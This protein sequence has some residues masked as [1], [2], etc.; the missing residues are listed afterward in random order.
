MAFTQKRSF[1]NPLEKVPLFPSRRASTPRA[2]PL[3]AP[4]TRSEDPNVM[5]GAAKGII[6][7]ILE[8]RLG[9]A[10]AQSVGQQIGRPGATIEGVLSG[11]SATGSAE[12]GRE[13]A[14]IQSE[15][16][17]QR[18]GVMPG[19]SQKSAVAE[20]A[21]SGAVSGIG[22][23]PIGM[24]VGAAAGAVGGALKN[25]KSNE[26]REDVRRHLENTRGLAT[27][28][29]FGDQVEKAGTAPAEAALAG[30]AGARRA[31]DLEAA[32]TASGLRDTGI[33]TL[34]SIAAGVQVPLEGLAATFGQALGEVHK[35]TSK[36]LGQPVGQ[37]GRDPIAMALEGLATLFLT[38][39]AT[40]ANPKAATKVP[41]NTGFETPPIFPVAKPEANPNPWGTMNPGGAL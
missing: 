28:E 15:I 18:E 22:G 27:P 14:G 39:G 38:P 34:A 40:S 33:G 10:L 9:P 7:P 4:S 25:R 2:V 41:E 36:A 32:I 3:V 23:G 26:K 30:G 5:S 35:Q 17:R 21:I 11:L 19:Q 1:T 6:G 8:A 37:I 12:L 29:A 13:L 16:N 31:Q 20:G 24:G